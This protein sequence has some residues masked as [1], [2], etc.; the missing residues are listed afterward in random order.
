M[1]AEHLAWLTKVSTRDSPLIS[2]ETAAKAALVCDMIRDATGGRMP[3]P[4][5]CTGPDGQMFYSWDRGR[6][7]L[8]LEIVPG[9]SDDWFYRDRESRDDHWLV[10][11]NVGDP[12]PDEVLAAMGFFY[13]D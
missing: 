4:A 3:V 9:E 12:L 1:N 7:H 2:P 11:Y 13:A 5:G 8:E 6:H 10:E